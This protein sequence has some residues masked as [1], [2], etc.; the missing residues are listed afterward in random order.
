MRDLL[1]IIAKG[2]QESKGENK[3]PKVIRFPKGDLPES[4][5][6]ILSELSNEDGLFNVLNGVAEE[7]KENKEKRVAEFEELEKELNELI[8]SQAIP[9][10]TIFELYERLKGDDTAIVVD[11][12]VV[13]INLDNGQLIDSHGSILPA[14]REIIESQFVL[15]S[16]YNAYKNKTSNQ[17][18][19]QKLIMVSKEVA[20]NAFEHGA[21]IQVE[22]TDVNGEVKAITL[23]QDKKN[24]LL[25]MEA[26]VSGVFYI[27]QK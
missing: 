2:I 3:D 4:L 26:I 13:R 15:E 17:G 23:Y 9:S 11:A 20:F 12:P 8:T 14:F 27:I 10:Y 5:A 6:G 22:F 16:E 7:M 1:E 19:K 25:P 21:D 24:V 18:D